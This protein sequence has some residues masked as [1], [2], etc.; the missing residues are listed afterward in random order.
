MY[1][2]LICVYFTM[3]L[4]RDDLIY[5]LNNLVQNQIW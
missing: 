2:P 5:E 1:A 4:D 3:Y